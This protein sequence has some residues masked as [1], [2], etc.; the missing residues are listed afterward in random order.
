M[1]F[2]WILDLVSA[3]LEP[4]KVERN[5]VGGTGVSGFGIHVVGSV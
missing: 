5:G 4:V 1:E 2:G 3:V